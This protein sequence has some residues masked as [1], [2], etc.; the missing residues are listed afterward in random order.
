ML[1]N[2]GANINIEDNRGQ[3]PLYS[4]TSAGRFQLTFSSL[5]KLKITLIHSKHR[6]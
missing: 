1:L 5:N 6:L 3:T 2:H 4:A